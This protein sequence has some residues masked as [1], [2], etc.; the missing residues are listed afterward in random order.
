MNAVAIET[1]SGVFENVGRM[2]GMRIR[3]EEDI[4]EATSKGLPAR[5]YNKADKVFHFPAGLIGSATT[6]RRRQESNAPLSR[7]E[8]E[9]LVRVLRVFA[10][11]TQLFEDDAKAIAWMKR[12]AKY[13]DSR[14]PI[15]PLELSA[16]DSGARLMEAQIT[17]TAYGMLG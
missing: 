6:I 12:P 14:P 10:E 13:L 8:S 4:L 2:L 17:K 16:T 3:S 15:S 9:A 1:R 11:A 7:S 5:T